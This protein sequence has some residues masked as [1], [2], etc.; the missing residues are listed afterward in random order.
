MSSSDIMQDNR[1]KENQILMS[2][3]HS[4]REVSFSCAV[5]RGNSFLLNNSQTLLEQLTDNDGFDA[6]VTEVKHEQ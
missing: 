3:T 2:E 6:T 5:G 4:A 1:K